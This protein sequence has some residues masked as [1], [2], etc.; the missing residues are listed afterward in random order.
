LFLLP[1]SDPRSSNSIN[2]TPKNLSSNKITVSQL[3]DVCFR[4]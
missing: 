2:K 4:G 1:A 3:D